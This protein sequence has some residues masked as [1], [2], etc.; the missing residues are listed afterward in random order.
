MTH[1]VTPGLAVTYIRST[2]EH[3]P[4]TIIGRSTREEGF[5]HLKYMRASFISPKIV[6]MTILCQGI[7]SLNPP[8]L[9][10]RTRSDRHFPDQAG[11]CARGGGGCLVGLKCLALS[12][13]TPPSTMH[14]I[15][16]QMGENCMKR[17]HVLQRGS[18]VIGGGSSI[19]KIEF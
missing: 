18:I 11:A 16:G 4:A 13:Q 10:T 14:S 15:A 1:V 17:V 3:A 2:A 6:R 19:K 7:G 12:A 8:C 9:S 5:I